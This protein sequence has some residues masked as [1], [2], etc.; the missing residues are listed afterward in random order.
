M[1]RADANTEWIPIDKLNGGIE[2]PS[3]EQK[4]MWKIRFFISYVA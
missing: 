4:S 2:L 1:E 3:K